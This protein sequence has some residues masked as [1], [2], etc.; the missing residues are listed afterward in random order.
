M[1]KRIKSYIEFY[2]TLH[3]NLKCKNCSMASPYFTP[4]F[5][6]YESFKR[7]CDKLKEFYQIDV[8]RFTGGEPTLHPEIAKFIAYPKQIG[9]AHKICVISNGIGLLSVSDEFWEHVDI[10]HLSVYRGT[11]INYDKIKTHIEKKKQQYPNLR[12]IEITDPEVIETLSAYNKD[13]ASKGASINIVPGKFKKLWTKEE[14]TDEEAQ[15]IWEKCWMKD[16]TFA[17]HQGRFYKCPIPMIKTK[18]Y[19]QENK[20]LPYDYDSDS[21]D[22]FAEDAH[23]RMEELHNSRKFL[24]ACKTCNGFNSAEDEDHSQLQSVNIEEII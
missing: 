22:L 21:V 9:L 8:A 20:E 1:Q 5:N 7:D 23:E 11:T 17:V 14:K 2:L 3:C 16:S 6:D 18:L 15:L 24:N 13:I 10:I 12:V 4:Q 19:Q